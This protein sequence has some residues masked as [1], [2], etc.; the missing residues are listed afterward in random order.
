MEE[1]A[2]LRQAQ[3]RHSA[4]FSVLVFLLFEL[5]RKGSF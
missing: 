2:I 3:D 1:I 5:R 4:P